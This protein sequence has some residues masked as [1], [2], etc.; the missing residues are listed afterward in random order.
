MVAMPGNCTAVW[1]IH[2]RATSLSTNPMNICVMTSVELQ[3]RQ[4]LVQVMQRLLRRRHQ[5]RLQRQQSQFIASVA[6][7]QLRLKDAV[8]IVQNKD[9]AVSHPAEMANDLPD[10]ATVRCP[11]VDGIEVDADRFVL[12]PAT[13][14]VGQET[15]ELLTSFW[16]VAVDERHE[17]AR[18]VLKA[19]R[20]NSR[21]TPH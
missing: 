16:P 21:P 14:M 1:S 19:R 17:D 7:N 15:Q 8:K 6:L 13:Q 9:N 10:S 2:C 3:G 4:I 20:A 12:D 18:R 5:R 11:V